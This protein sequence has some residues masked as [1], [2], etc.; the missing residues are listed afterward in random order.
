MYVTRFP[1]PGTWRH[2]WDPPPSVAPPTP[3]RGRRPFF[4]HDR[5]HRQRRVPAVAR[6]GQRAGHGRRGGVAQGALDLEQV[7]WPSPR[8]P[9]PDRLG[10]GGDAGGELVERGGGGQQA[11][12]LVGHPPCLHGPPPIHGAAAPTRCRAVPVRPAAPTTVGAMPSRARARPRRPAS[13]AVLNRLDLRGVAD[14]DLAARL[15]RPD[16]ADR[17][18]R[19]RG[20]GHP[21]R[22]P[23]AAATRPCG[24][25]T[26]RFDGVAASSCGCRSR[27]DR[28]RPRR[29]PTP[30]LRGR[31][32][33]GPRRHRGL[34]PH[35]AAARPPLRARRHH[36]RGPRT[37]PSTGPGCYVPGGRAAYPSSVLMTAV[38]ARVA[39][40]DRGR[41]VR[42]RPTATPAGG[43]AHAG[44]RGR[45]RRRRGLRHRRGPGHRRH[46]LRHRDRSGAGRRHRRPGQRLR[47][48]GQARGGRRGRACR[49]PSPG[50]SEIV[51][52]ADETTP[53]DLRR[54]RRHRAGRARPR[55][56][57][58]ADHLVA[59]RRPTPSTPR[60][61]G[62][63][64]TRPAGPT[65][66]PTSP[67][68]GY[69]AL[70]DGPEPGHGGGQ[71]H[72]PR[73]PPAD[74]R[75]P[76]VAGAAGAPRRRRVL[77][78]AGARPRS[79]DYIAGPSH[80]LPTFGSARFAS[81]LTVDDFVKQVH[82]DHRRPGRLRP[83]GAV[84]R[85]A[86]PSAEGFDAHAAVDPAAPAEARDVGQP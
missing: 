34:P 13:C 18:A 68:A 19:G 77:R 65:S 7:G 35:P 1:P 74:E 81:A 39:G 12:E 66:R 36:G 31:A 78:A 45:G 51:V 85:D 57:G 56:P 11:G 4:G 63:W 86:W 14:A 79:G 27:R 28:R 33:G 3:L 42:A 49:R 72:R 29:R 70:V 16:L 17:R 62:W 25:L 20:A 83:G 80:V 5:S 71:P 6:A 54:H 61:R 58:L 60:S 73:A 52:V 26:E 43:G 46:G 59:G 44:R 37:C 55:R 48:P 40:V 69:L 75:R 9:P 50:P 32:G 76:R 38:P 15:P 24:E 82:V 67:R 21:R 2:I 41:A 10:G 8:C 22:G 84:R 53:P 64:P 23:R 30:T 47:G